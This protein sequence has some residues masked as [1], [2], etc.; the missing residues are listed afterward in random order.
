[1]YEAKFVIHIVDLLLVSHHHILVE[2]WCLCCLVSLDGQR[3]IDLASLHR[4]Q[5]HRAELHLALAV[6][7]RASHVQVKLLAVERLD[8]H[9]HFL[10]G[11]HCNSLAE[12]CH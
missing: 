5:Y 6:L 9:Y 12:T 4:L 8:L 10:V 2:E 11:N 3:E 7:L 1:M